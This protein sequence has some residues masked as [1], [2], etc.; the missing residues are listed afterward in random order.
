MPA[1][2]PESVDAFFATTDHPHR[3]ALLAIRR[4]ILGADPSISEGIKWNVPS[5]R[6]SEWFATLHLRA[7]DG[8]GVILHFGAKKRD[9]LPPRDAIPDPAAL[10]TWL[11]PDRAMVVFRDAADVEAKGKAFEELLRGWVE[12]V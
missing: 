10:L 2:A 11:A 8:V 12:H 4:A 3:D 5:F 1:A 7:K 9:N 6:T